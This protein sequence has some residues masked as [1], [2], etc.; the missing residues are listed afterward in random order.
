MRVLVCNVELSL[1]ASEDERLG[2]GVIDTL[3]DKDN[4]TEQLSDNVPLTDDECASPNTRLG[5]L[6]L[7]A[8]RSLAASHGVDLESAER[9]PRK[10]SVV[11]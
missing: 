4:P 11:L 8:E 5:D 9:K 2:S 1:E 7:S 3:D 10:L 6:R